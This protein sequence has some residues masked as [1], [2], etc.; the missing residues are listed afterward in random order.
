MIVDFQ[1]Y[2]CETSGQWNHGNCVSPD[3]Q[4]TFQVPGGITATIYDPTTL[5]EIA[6]ST[7]NPNIPFRPTQVA[8]ST[9]PNNPPAEPTADPDSRF[10]NGAGVCV[11]S[12]S[13]P[14]TFTFAG[15]SL[16]QTVVWTVQ[17]DT[18]HS[19]YQKIGDLNACNATDQG[20]GYDSLNVG[21]LSYPNAPY[22]GTDVDEDIAY[23]SF[24]A[25][26]YAPPITPL[27]PESDWTGYRP[28]GQIILN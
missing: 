1:S 26:N 21:A 17:F 11:Y 13:V 28:L 12:K 18:S 14:L 16:P 23:R 24:Y 4:G 6:H 15:E 7:I 5:T 20:C 10:K 25:P 2:A 19:G 8:D 9:C 22:A 3:P 27:G